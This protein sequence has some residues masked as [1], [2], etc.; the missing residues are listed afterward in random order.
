MHDVAV[1]DVRHG[2]NDV[3]VVI[4]GQVKGHAHVVGHSWW[5]ISVR[6]S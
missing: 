4:L 3:V 1:V 2:G 5:D 6:I